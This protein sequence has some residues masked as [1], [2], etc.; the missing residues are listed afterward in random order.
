MRDNFFFNVLVVG[1]I[2]IALS[3]V[4]GLATWEQMNGLEFF[5]SPAVILVWMGITTAILFDKFNIGGL[6]STRYVRK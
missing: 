2:S 3:I 6:L 1:G 5:G 4:F